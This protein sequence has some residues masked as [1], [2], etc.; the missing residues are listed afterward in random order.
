MTNFGV[1]TPKESKVQVEF[2][3]DRQDFISTEL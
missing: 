3:Q 2:V 1:L